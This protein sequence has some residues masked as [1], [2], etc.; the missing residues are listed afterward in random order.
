MGDFGGGEEKATETWGIARD[1]V[2][3][4]G[5]ILPRSLRSKPPE[6]SS[7]P[8]GMTESLRIETRILG[9][10]PPQKAVLTCATGTGEKPKN[11]ARNGCAT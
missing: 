6:G 7:F 3:S 8:V 5:E 11:T 2:W 4:E 9:G 10:G 1:G